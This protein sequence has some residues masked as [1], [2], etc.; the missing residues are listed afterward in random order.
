MQKVLESIQRV[1]FT[2][3]TPRQASIREKRGPSLGKINVKV[4]QRSHH[5]LKFEDRSHEATERQQRCARSKAWNLAKKHLQAQRKRKSCILLFVVDSGA[6]MHMVSKKDLNSAELETMKTSR[7]PTTVM[8]ANG[9]VRTYS[10]K[11]CFLKKFPQFIPSR[12][13]EDHGLYLPLDQLSKTTSHQ[14]WQ[15]Y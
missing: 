9:E 3:S 14:E 8:T 12:F 4:P 5:A 11:L 10:S 6:N 1:R 13:C 15:E 2:K 7:S